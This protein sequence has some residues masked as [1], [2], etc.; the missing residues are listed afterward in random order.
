MCNTPVIE[1]EYIPLLP[2]E[3]HRML[4]QDSANMRDIFGRDVRAV[5]KN[6]VIGV[7]LNVQCASVALFAAPQE[8]GYDPSVEVIELPRP[9][10]VEVVS[11]IEPDLR[12]R[13]WMVDHGGALVDYL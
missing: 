7:V 8:G 10:I 9:G 11:A 1:H 4:P 12:A 5:A 13:L 2:I 3:Q 6:A